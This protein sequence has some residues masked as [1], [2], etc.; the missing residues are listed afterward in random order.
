[1][2]AELVD[3]DRLVI[4]VSFVEHEAFSGYECL[5]SVIRTELDT[6]A[7]HPALVFIHQREGI[8]WIVQECFKD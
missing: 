2:L 4:L 6:G 5:N 8:S 7:V 1:M 3:I